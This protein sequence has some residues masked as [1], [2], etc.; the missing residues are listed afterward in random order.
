MQYNT[1]QITLHHITQYTYNIMSLYLNMILHVS[2]KMVLLCIS[3]F[4]YIY[5][6][7]DGYAYLTWS[8]F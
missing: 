3:P 1:T 4:I 5:Y 8:Q 6:Y 7:N 2:F